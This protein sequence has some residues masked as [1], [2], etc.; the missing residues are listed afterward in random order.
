MKRPGSSKR[1]T[2]KSLLCN[3]PCH[4]PS[5]LPLIPP[6]GLAAISLKALLIVSEGCFESIWRERAETEVT[7][8]SKNRLLILFAAA[9]T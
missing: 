6:S 9:N 3:Y 2:Q 1:S 4:S 7:L 5:A 8:H